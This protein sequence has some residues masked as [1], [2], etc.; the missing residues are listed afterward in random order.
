MEKS[1][2]LNNQASFTK[3][4]VKLTL[5]VAEFFQTLVYILM[6]TSFIVLLIIFLQVLRGQDEK[7]E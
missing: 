2:S 4:K 7:T 5:T 6:V 1:D 3:E